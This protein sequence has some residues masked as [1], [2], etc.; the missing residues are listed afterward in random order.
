MRGRRESPVGFAAM[1]DAKDAYGME[2][3]M[4]SDAV[5]ADTKPKFGW[6]DSLKS[7]YIA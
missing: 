7:L 6:L 4:E 2:L 3:L 5:V 1:A